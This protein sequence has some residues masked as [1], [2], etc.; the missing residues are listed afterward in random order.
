MFFKGKR[1]INYIK[2]AKKEVKRK[3]E[4]N[5]LEDSFVKS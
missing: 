1:E 3:T 5:I 2:Q 4:Q